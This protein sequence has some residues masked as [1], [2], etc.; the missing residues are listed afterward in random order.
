MERVKI[1]KIGEMRFCLTDY[2]EVD[3]NQSVDCT[4]D[5]YGETYAVDDVI[6]MEKY[7]ELCRLFALT[8]GFGEKLV[9]DWFGD[10]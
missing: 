4:F 5:L 7:W 9:Y 3:F 6:C 1:D 10:K 2:R 8:M